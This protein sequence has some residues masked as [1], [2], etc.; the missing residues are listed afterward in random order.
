M[1]LY[2]D[3]YSNEEASL[4]WINAP[5]RYGEAFFSTGFFIE[6]FHPSYEEYEGGET[7]ILI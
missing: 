4:K 6:E 7:G 3:A 2:L 1:F 5:V